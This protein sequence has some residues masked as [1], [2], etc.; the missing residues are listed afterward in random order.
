MKTEE[1]K[2]TKR[3]SKQIVALIGVILLV[4]LYL[5]TLF[6]AILVPDAKSGLFQA[7]LAATIGIPFL[8]WIYVWM[9]GKLTGNHTFAD[10]DIGGKPEDAS[11]K[12]E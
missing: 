5:I 7:C 8:V 11:S 2:K 3:N 9:Y 6:V 10:L 4:S 12:K 1:P